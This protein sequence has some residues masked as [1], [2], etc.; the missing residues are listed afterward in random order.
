MPTQRAAAFVGIHNENEFYSHHYLSE[1]F[2]RDIGETTEA[3]R[4]DAADAD[5]PRD[6]PRTSSSGRSPA[7]TGDAA[8]STSG[9][10]APSPG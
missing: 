10:A 6:K 3:W 8:S 2:S 5:E 1:I 7:N 9:N 4:K